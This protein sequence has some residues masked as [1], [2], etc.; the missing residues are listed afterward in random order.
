MVFIPCRGGISHSPA[1]YASP[2]DA[3]LAVEIV[4]NAVLALCGE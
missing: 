2:A 4:L 3:A 1:E